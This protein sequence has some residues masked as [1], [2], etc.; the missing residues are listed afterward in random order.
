MSDGITEAYKK[1][2]SKETLIVNIFG[3]PGSGKSIMCAD[4]F[5]KLK[6][7]HYSAEM[8]MEYVKDEVWEENSN[9][10]SNQL[11][12]LGNQ[13]Q[14]LYRLLNKVD[15]IIVDSPILISIIYDKENNNLFEQYVVEKFKN[16]R[17]FN[18]Y[19]ERN[20]EEYENN[21][22]LHT[23]REAIK[24]DKEIKNLL[25]KHNIDFISMKMDKNETNKILELIKEKI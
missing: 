17:N 22:R 13:H 19:I 14:R 12:I 10:I 9:A 5:S 2:K 3:G 8:A 1:S 25:L 20:N 7:Q 21:G 4:L 11:F 24:K 15:V 18:I 6:W 23:L 16:Y